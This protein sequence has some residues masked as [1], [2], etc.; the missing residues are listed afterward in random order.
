MGHAGFAGVLF[1]PCSYSS[2]RLRMF[3]AD[4]LTICLQNMYVTVVLRLCSADCMTICF[5]SMHVTDV[6]LTYV[7]G[8]LPI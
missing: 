8:T 6:R 1:L 3:F 7:Q 2:S 4:C 5:R